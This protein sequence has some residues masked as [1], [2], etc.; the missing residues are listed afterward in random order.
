M[1]YKITEALRD[2]IAEREEQI[3]KHGYDSDHDDNDMPFAI[4]NVGALYALEAGS[5]LYKDVFEHVWPATWATEHWK[6]GSQRKSLVKAA[7]M[8][9]AE[10]EAID[11]AEEQETAKRS[12]SDFLKRLRHANA[13]RAKIWK[14]TGT[15]ADTFMATE[16]AEE[17]GEV[18][19]AVKKLHRSRYGIVGNKKTEQELSQNLSEEIGD[20]MV[21]LDRLSNLFGIDIEQVTREKFNAKSKEVGIDIFVE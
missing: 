21:C 16:L 6:P 5:A 18:L 13:A 14:Y 3:A 7:A 1:S 2:V 15:D 11:R 19:G 9:L 12:N 8:I 20:V 4:S 10:I 17:V